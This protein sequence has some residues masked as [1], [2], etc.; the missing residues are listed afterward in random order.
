MILYY[1]FDTLYCIRLDL[2]VAGLWINYNH[3]STSIK[4]NP[5]NL[6]HTPNYE[7]KW[8]KYNLSIIKWCERYFNADKDNAADAETEG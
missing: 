7:E 8:E 4:V 1:P 2:Y 3:N 5:F 6:G